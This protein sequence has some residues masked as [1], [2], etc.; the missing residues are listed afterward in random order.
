MTIYFYSKVRQAP[1]LEIK[2]QGDEIKRIPFKPAGHGRIPT[3]T[4]WCANPHPP[5]TPHWQFRIELSHQ[6]YAAPAHKGSFDYYETGF[7]QL[8]VQNGQI[9]NY[10]PAPAHAQPRVLKIPHFMGSLPKRTLYIYLPRGYDQ[11]PFKKYPVLYMH[12]GQNCF[13]TFVQ[14]SYSG[15]WRADEIATNLIAAGQMRECLIV[16]I[17]NGGHQRIA[18][19]LP[20]YATHRPFQ[21]ENEL[22]HSTIPGRAQQTYTYYAQEI[23]PFIQTYYR[24]KTGRQNRALCGSSMGGLFSLYIGWEHPEFAQHIAALSTSFWITRRQDNTLAAINRL[25]EGPK[26]DIRLWLDS[27]T[28]DAPGRGDDGMHDTISARN[29]LLQKGYATGQNFRYYLHDGAT[30]SE[31]SWS[32]RLPEIFKFLFPTH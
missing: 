2:T 10:E 29:A 28:L 18:E 11:H 24:A 31:A 30:H 4:L 7:R 19:Y 3:E 27:G 13:Q 14:D 25:H 12:D 5:P 26:R 6:T 1:T 9:Y 21:N 8:W 17:S 16:G 20:P 32:A 15:S 22:P 23:D